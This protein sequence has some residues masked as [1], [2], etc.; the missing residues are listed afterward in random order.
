MVRLRD[1]RLPH[2]IHHPLSVFFFFR[3]WVIE[4]GSF[5]EKRLCLFPP[6]DFVNFA[7]IQ[8]EEKKTIPTNAPRK[9]K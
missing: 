2:S 7:T 8:G 6:Q 4:K 1:C 9:E 3:L 5:G